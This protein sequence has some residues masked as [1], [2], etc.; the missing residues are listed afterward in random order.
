MSNAAAVPVVEHGPDRASLSLVR[1]ADPAGT[2]RDPD[3]IERNLGLL[4]R[5]ASYFNPEVRGLDQLP[6]HGPF[7][8]VG[9]HS[10]GATPPDM[11]VLMTA[12]WRQRGVEE[13]VYGLFH[14]AFMGVPRVG[15]VMRKAGGIEAAPDAAEA[16]LRAGGSVLVYPGGDHEAFRPWTD[17]HQ[18]DF[19]GRTGFIKLALRTGVPIVPATSCGAHNSVM[20]L[21]R[22][23]R[24]VRLLPHLRMMRV[25]VMPIMLGLPW[26]V[27][28]GLPTLPLPARVVTQVGP[29]VDLPRRFGPEVADDEATVQA[30]YDEV[31]TLMQRT[32]D[33]LVAERELD[34]A[35]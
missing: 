12:W 16:A 19:N 33:G 22:G 30:I 31:T 18:I 13:P 7:L 8:I 34:L 28:F 26:G 25:K 10:G 15:D 17:R 20:V 29:V 24:L 11:P 4:E 3:F 1:D 6:K 21:S 14:S 27:S 32:M 2:G 5:W 35:S 9:N 23:D